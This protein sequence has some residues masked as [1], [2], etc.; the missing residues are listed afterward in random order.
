[1][2]SGPTDLDAA[3]VHDR[4][5]QGGRQVVGARRT[6]G[7]LPSRARPRRPCAA[8]RRCQRPR[9]GVEVEPELRVRR[10]PAGAPG[11]AGTPALGPSGHARR[12]HVAALGHG[13][14]A[15]CPLLGALAGHRRQALDERAELVLA[16]QPHDGVAVVVAEAGRLQV[17]LDRQVADDRREV[18]AHADLVDVLAQLVAELGRA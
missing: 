4:G 5:G 1:M 11:P 16:E 17:D 3:G 18:L 9:D 6:G 13:S 2:R 10:A 7:R 14:Q 12:R 15:L 8:S